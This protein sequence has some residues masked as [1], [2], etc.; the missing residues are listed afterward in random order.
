MPSPLDVRDTRAELAHL[1]WLQEMAGRRGLP[2]PLIALVCLRVAQLSACARFGAAA[3]DLIGGGETRERLT[4]LPAWQ[5]SALFTRCERAAL[6]WSEA[7]T[8]VLQRRLPEAAWK[9]LTPQLAPGELVELAL[10]AAQRDVP[11]EL[12]ASLTPQLTPPQLDDLTVLVTVINT[13][14]HCARTGGPA[15]P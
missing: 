15:A 2:R 10:A 11:E 9:R 13:H 7:V 5:E 4:A 14:I 6:T 3:L 1:Q 12:W 8:C